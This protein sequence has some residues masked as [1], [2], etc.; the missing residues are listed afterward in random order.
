MKMPF[1]YSQINA[2]GI[3]VGG[4][5]IKSG[6]F[7]V[8]FPK[9]FFS[10][11]T[12]DSNNS[13]EYVYRQIV[14]SINR[15]QRQAS[16]PIGSVGI[17]W[18]GLV[19]DGVII[20]KSYDGIFQRLPQNEINFVGDLGYRLE[21][22]T[23]IRPI[24]ITNSAIAEAYGLFIFNL[25]RNTVIL[26]C[27][28]SVTYA[29]IDK[30]GNV[31]SGLGGDIGGLTIYM[32]DPPF[33][34]DFLSFEGIRRIATGAGIKEDRLQ[35]IAAQMSQDNDASN[36]ILETIARAIFDTIGVLK[37]SPFLPEIWEVHIC[38][39]VIDNLDLKELLRLLNRYDRN[40]PKEISKIKFSVYPRYTQN[41]GVLGAGYLANY[42][43]QTGAPPKLIK[44]SGFWSFL[45]SKED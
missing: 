40:K 27:D 10:V 14:D 7:G 26:K 45:K 20:P 21:D 3:D 37:S 1:D 13:G 5:N 32:K 23:G 2:V 9:E 31:D 17:G 28:T 24:V 41:L 15:F 29:Y 44:K 12:W 25:R 22:D 19:E 38:G 4:I 33:V 8:D 39:E 16:Q 35:D 42:I 34:R 6:Y 11:P 18:P 43:R 36:I 30:Q